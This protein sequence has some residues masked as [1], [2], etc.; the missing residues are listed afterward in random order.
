MAVRLSINIFE[1]V[2]QMSGVFL[3]FFVGRPVSAI[4]EQHQSRV[5]NVIQRRDADLE[6]AHPVRSSYL[7]QEAALASSFRKL[8]ANVLDISPA[9]CLIMG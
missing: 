9:L 8:S 7:G 1:E 6:N 2:K 5:F 4:V 3:R